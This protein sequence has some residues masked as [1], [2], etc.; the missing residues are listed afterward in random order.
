MGSSRVYYVERQRLTA[1]D[2]RA[3]QEY[4]AGLDER[5]NLNQHAP[6]VVR[7]LRVG[8]DERGRLVVEPGVAV[9]AYGR[10]LLLAE[11]L[12]LQLESPRVDVWLLYCLRPLRPRQPG[13]VPCS[14]ENAPRW[15]EDAH[16]L[17]EEVEDNQPPSAPADGAV[18]LGRLSPPPPDPPP[19]PPPAPDVAYTSVRG[20]EVKDPGARASMQVGPRTGR[21]QTAFAV[22]VADDAGNTTRR[23]ALERRAGNVI[24]GTVE[25]LDYRASAT[26][27]LFENTLRLLVEAKRPGPSG[28]QI[29]F[30][31]VE[32]MEGQSEIAELAFLNYSREPGLPPSEEMT[33]VRKS[34]KLEEELKAFNQ[35]SRL[36]RLDIVSRVQP[37]KEKAEREDIAQMKM[38]VDRESKARDDRQVA[39][40]GAGGTL[41]FDELPKPE[42]EAGNKFKP[43]GCYGDRAAADEPPELEAPMGLSFRPVAE[44]PEGQPLPRVY[45]AKVPDG[46]RTIEQLRV[47]LGEKKDADET[48]RFAV[49]RSKPPGP[50][51]KDWLTICGTCAITI[52]AVDG[53][54]T[55][56]PVG[57]QVFGTIEQAPIRPDHTD[58]D[59]TSRLVAAWLEGL[60]STVDA[61]TVVVITIEQPPR[62]IESGKLWSYTLRLSNTG[63]A[64]VTAEKVLETLFVGSSTIPSN[65]PALPNIPGK[66]HVDKTVDHAGA[67]LPEGEIQVEVTASGKINNFPWWRSGPEPPLPIKVVLPPTVDFSD[68]PE[69]VPPNLAWSHTFEAIN[70][71]ESS[72]TLLSA[73]LTES[74][75]AGP[76]IRSL[77]NRTI[78]LNGGEAHEFIPATHPNGMQETFDYEFKVQYRWEDGVTRVFTQTHEIVVAPQLAVAI[79]A[80]ASITRGTD[81]S[82]TLRLE[83]VNVADGLVQVKSLKLRLRPPNNSSFMD[84]DGV[85]PLDLDPGE[86]F[87]TL[88]INGPRVNTSDTQVTLEIQAV[89]EHGGRDWQPPVFTQL[90][91]VTEPTPP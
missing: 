76:S 69:S 36:V 9:D 75:N 56:L 17:V 38:R 8:R 54:T 52:P 66:N 86:S 50:D 46:E 22:S 65:L 11:P 81:W 37:S 70:N 89:Y 80:P 13:R 47:D 2:L 19:D 1:A 88:A 85:T 16:V 45:V 25:L 57:L 23:L 10:E 18:F 3:E 77:L 67:D 68:V 24:E 7:G 31:A 12:T 6:G 29:Q 91:N 20:R 72:L 39:L 44:P 78:D 4:L 55:I 74:T 60:R 26:I 59:F 53:G 87:T 63:D 33:V 51:V 58:P 73:T 28:Q 61:S 49:R 82:F 90:I 42:K 15:R 32:K 35:T 21:D 79:N 62:I 14:D 34:T 40:S 5:H 71:S 27:S 64:P 43:R 41:E 30:S 83:N 84:I 48:D